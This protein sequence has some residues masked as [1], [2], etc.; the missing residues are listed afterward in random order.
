MNKLKFATEKDFYKFFEPLHYERITFSKEDLK[1]LYLD[2]QT[3]IG[4]GEIPKEEEFPTYG[5]VRTI[6]TM[7]KFCAIGI[8]FP[9]IDREIKKENEKATAMVKYNWNTVDIIFKMDSTGMFV[10]ELPFPFSIIHKNR[11]ITL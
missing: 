1:K 3:Y 6:F 8:Y 5:E 7:E 2:Y 11:T 9:E 4:F 10:S